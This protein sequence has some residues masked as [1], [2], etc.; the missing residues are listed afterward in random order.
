M[1]LAGGCFCGALR[2]EVTAAPF[3]QSNCHCS[4]CRRSSAAPFMAWFSAP[5]IGVR[6]TQ[7][8]L[9]YFRSSAAAQRGF[10][11][12]CGTQLTFEEDGAE[13]IDLSL[14]SLDDPEQLPP[15]DHIHTV[16]QLTWIKLD[17]GLP[18]YRNRR[19]QG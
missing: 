3:N 15:L 14:C 10:C 17:D 12:N 5:R 11:G 2:Y 8:T 13:E 19:S 4:M 18:Q 16:S 1:I 9:N 6:F 7:G